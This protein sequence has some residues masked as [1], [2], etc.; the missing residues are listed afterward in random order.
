MLSLTKEPSSITRMSDAFVDVVSDPDTIH[1]VFD[2]LKY[3][4][5]EPHTHRENWEIG[6]TP[7]SHRWLD[8]NGKTLSGDSLG[9]ACF[10]LM[11]GVNTHL[12]LEELDRLAVTGALDLDGDTL[13]ARP[14]DALVQKAKIAFDFGSHAMIFPDRSKGESELGSL[15]MRFFRVGADFQLAEVLN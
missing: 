11:I 8:Q 1:A 3:Y 13:I 7:A 9:L 14:V 10:Y 6:L 4:K 15:D 12:S 2:A 5:C